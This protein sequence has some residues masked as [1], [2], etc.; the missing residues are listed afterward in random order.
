MVD[1]SQMHHLWL[2]SDWY[3]NIVINIIATHQYITPDARY[4]HWVSIWI[5]NHKAVNNLGMN[6]FMY[7]EVYKIKNSQEIFKH[8]LQEGY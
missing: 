6:Y 1:A 5:G 4:L 3:Q 8:K 7:A 2:R